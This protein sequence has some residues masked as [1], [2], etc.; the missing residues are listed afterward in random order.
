MKNQHLKIK[1][2]PI[3]NDSNIIGRG[4]DMV[5]TSKQLKPLA[6]YLL[7]NLLVVKVLEAAVTTILVGW[8]IVDQLGSYSGSNLVLKNRQVSVHGNL[9]GRQKKLESII[10]EIETYRQHGENNSSLEVHNAAEVVSKKEK[11]K[12]TLQPLEILKQTL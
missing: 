4:S 10:T 5:T 7:G 8:G 1:I 3:P 6:D 2:K 11:V 9:M 12:D